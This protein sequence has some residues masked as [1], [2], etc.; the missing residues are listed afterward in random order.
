MKVNDAALEPGT[1]FE[2]SHDGIL[3]VGDT[4]VQMKIMDEVDA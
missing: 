1:A 3:S 4:E 2:V